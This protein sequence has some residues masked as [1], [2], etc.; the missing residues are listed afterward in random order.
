M[1]AEKVR[2]VLAVYS[3]MRELTDALAEAHDEPG[4]ADAMLSS[5]TDGLDPRKKIGQA[6]SRK[7]SELFLQ[8]RYVPESGAA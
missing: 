8:P 4:G 5:C 6:L 1:S 3:T 7:L 2:E